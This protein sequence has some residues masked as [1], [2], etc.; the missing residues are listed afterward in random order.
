MFV[1]WYVV[2]GK[3]RPHLLF[4]STTGFVLSKSP[5]F[6][7]SSTTDL[8]LSKKYADSPRDERRAESPDA[9]RRQ[10]TVLAQVLCVHTTSRILGKHQWTMC[11]LLPLDL[12]K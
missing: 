4:S 6:V 7:F 12:E 8:V 11:A 10:D 2:S 5:H 1:S 9:I 3:V